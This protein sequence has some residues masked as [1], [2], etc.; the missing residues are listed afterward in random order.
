MCHFIPVG[1]PD[2]CFELPWMH[3]ITCRTIPRLQKNKKKTLSR[4]HLKA[5]KPMGPYQSTIISKWSWFLTFSLAR[6]KGF[7]L[8]DCHQT[9]YSD[10][11]ITPL[12]LTQFEVIRSNRTGDMSHQKLCFWLPYSMVWYDGIHHFLA[13]FTI[14]KSSLLRKVDD[15]IY[16]SLKH[17]NLKFCYMP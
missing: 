12:L 1:T 4:I 2:P 9:L 16:D 17:L 13:N 15:L 10:S 8:F 5:P 7:P 3:R 11:A 14:S 6:N